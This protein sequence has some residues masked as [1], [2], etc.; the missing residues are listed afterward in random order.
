MRPVLYVLSALAVMGL[1]FWAYRQN[2]A[3]QEVLK[4]VTQLQNQIGQL[5]DDL[6]MQQAEWAYENR[7]DRLRELAILNFDKLGLLAMT[8][9]QFG[10]ISEVALPQAKSDPAAGV[11]TP[12]TGPITHAVE[13]SAQTATKPAKT[14][15]KT[16]AKEQTP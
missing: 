11:D 6:T 4:Q 13:A 8:P 5:H 1:A 3:T 2:Y 16:Q 9:D 12:V 10:A 14:P 15:N 7:P